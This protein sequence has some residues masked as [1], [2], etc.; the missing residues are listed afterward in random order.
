MEDTE[1]TYSLPDVCGPAELSNLIVWLRSRASSAHQSVISETGIRKLIELSF[2]LSLSPDEG[3]YPR[4][5]LGVEW[6]KKPHNFFL[7]VKFDKPIELNEIGDLR[8]LA[9]ACTTPHLAL[10]ITEQDD[11]LWCIGLTNTGPMGMS[12]Q[13]GRPED[14]AGG[15]HLNFSVRIQDPGHIYIQNYRGTIELKAG[16]I[17]RTAPFWLVPAF[18][19]FSKRF[20]E[21]LSERI[22][23][24]ERNDEDYS[25]WFGG[26]GTVGSKILSTMERLLNS[27]LD[28]GHGGAFV[29][30]PSSND[31]TIDFDIKY[32]YNTANLNLGQNIVDFWVQCI[33]TSS[34]KE[35]NEFQRELE[36]WNQAKAR[37][38][39]NTEA[40][41]GL[42]AIDGCVVFN[43]CLS[44]QG[45]GGFIDISDDAV[46]KLDRTYKLERDGDIV[47]YR[48]FIDAVGGTRHQSA[49]RLCAKHSDA[50][51]IV[52]SQDRHL[53]IFCSDLD[54]NVRRYGPLDPDYI[55]N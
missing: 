50:I 45:F 7:A 9:P 48:E 29:I 32:T 8:R 25:K 46:E 2:Y 43:D 19:E 4:L 20:T 39:T 11:S 12:S 47:P 16:K 13:P 3:R 1:N 49:A 54:R 10:L 5:R 40:A 36:K 23:E 31:G 35:L 18:K 21:K 52:V 37:L 53:H 22:V 33:R 17:R 24:L 51:A 27:C 41:S 15:G 26:I 44:V 55:L 28:M 6:S 42:S 38:L 14:L 30:L 34:A